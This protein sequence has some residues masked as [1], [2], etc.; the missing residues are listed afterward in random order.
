MY[1]EK[2]GKLTAIAK[3]A[4]RKNSKFTATTSPFCFGEYVLFKGRSMYS[5]NDAI[6]INSFQ[7]FLD[8]LESIAYGSYMNE[9]INIGTVDNDPNYELFRDFVT[10]YYF[11]LDKA[12][13]N[14]LLIRGFELKFLKYM[15][16]GLNFDACVNCGNKINNS[17]FVEFN[18]PGFLCK[19]CISSW[20]V[21]ISN[22]AYNTMKYI[23]STPMKNIY[24]LTLD[25]HLKKE[26]ESLT[27]NMINQC[28]GKN[29]KSLDILNYNLKE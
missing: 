7:N 28:L 4:K 26:L 2:L 3:N 21:K 16:Y 11:L 17:N 6:I 19:N 14:D 5:M 24:K 23:L 1:T 15:G 18:N 8:S 10:A 12:V 9:L 20:S 29:P 27:K 25:V 22:S 13:D